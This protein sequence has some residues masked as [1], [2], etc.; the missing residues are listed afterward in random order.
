MRVA[1]SEMTANVT[2]TANTK[3]TAYEDSISA[4][5]QQPVEVEFDSTSRFVLIANDGA[6]NLYISFD[7]GTTYCTIQSGEQFGFGV[8]RDSVLMYGDTD[9]RLWVM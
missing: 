2:F 9:Y 3:V 5:A 4:S 6:T 7:G 1:N 8:A